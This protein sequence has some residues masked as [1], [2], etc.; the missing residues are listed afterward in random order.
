MY[1][2]VV[3]AIAGFEGYNTFGSVASMNNNPGN[4]MYGTFAQKTGSIGPDLQGYA[5]YPTQQ[6]G[7]NAADQLVSNYANKGATIQSLI[8][9]W[10]PS[11]APGNTP[12]S[13]ANYV[14]YVSNQLGVSPDTPVSSLANGAT[15]TSTS[16]TGGFLS[17]IVDK[18][19]PISDYNITRYTFLLLG[20]GFVIVGI[21]ALT[22]QSDVVD[23]IVSGAVTAGKTAAKAGAAAAV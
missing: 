17:G 5:I 12:Q 21:L 16:S 14:K 2:S 11:N 15:P 10:A 7:F 13:T 1:D 8:E 9:S 4:I 19:N 6:T 22:K 20:M 3:N 18:V 23:T